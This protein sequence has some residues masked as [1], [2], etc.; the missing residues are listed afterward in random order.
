MNETLFLNPPAA[1]NAIEA[2]TQELQFAMASEPRTGMLLRTLAATK[3][4]G[5]ILELG[6][7]TGLATAWLLDGMDAASTLISVDTDEQV[8]Q[9]A[10]DVLGQDKRLTL[11]AVDAC[12]FLWRQKQ[13]SFD[14]VFA[15][16]MPGK[17]VALDEAL[18]LVKPGGYYIVDDM[19]PQ[20]T[21]PEG[22]DQKAAALME[23]LAQDT[24]F[25]SAAMSW[26]SGIIV[27]VRK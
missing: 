17:Y 26:A 11:L 21:W 12:G 14:L 3:P 23:Q 4:G 20:P 27:M 18:D 13:A 10:R 16:A 15:D 24:R 25:R 7:G 5:R 19:L 22:H 1:V 8:Q 9:V 6:T 2:R